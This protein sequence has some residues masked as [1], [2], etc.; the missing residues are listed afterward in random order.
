MTGPTTKRLDTTRYFRCLTGLMGAMLLTQP[1]PVAAAAGQADAEARR[2]ARRSPIVEAVET[3][4]DAVVNIAATQV[5]EVRDIFSEFFDEW[6]RSPAPRRQ[7]QYTSLGSGFPIHPDGYVVTNAHVVLRATSL[8]AVFADQQEYEAR[9]IAIDE[10]HDLA[11]LKI[12]GDRPLPAIRL[13]RSDDLMIG[14]TVIAIGNP[15]GYH[16]TVT[17]GIISATERTLN[18]SERRSY[19]DLIQTDASI[20]P[21]NSG[22]PLLNILG[23]LIGINT[24]IR[25]DAQNIGFAIPVDSLRKLLPDMLSVEQHRRLLVGLRLDWRSVPYV[26][27]IRGPATQTGIEPGDVLL[28]VNGV[29]INQDLDFYVYLLGMAPDEALR[30]RLQRGPRTV[31][32]TIWPQAIPIPDGAKLLRDKFGLTARLLS[33]EQARQISPRLTGGLAIESVESDSP[34]ERAGL[35]RGHLIVMI[36]RYFPTDP[37][38]LGQLLE[39]INRG[40][41]IP[42]R[43]MEIR[44]NGTIVMLEGELTAR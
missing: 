12:D 38:K 2:T 21:G 16:H 4:R 26:T 25:G 39:N 36:G 13:G 34:A 9:P 37:E 19:R 18:I 17:T 35:K 31:T 22:G 27:T 23:E 6:L 8:K 43:V 41:Q 30:V 28:S 40:D 33:P 44:R 29:E 7:R 20:N 3:S 42:V 1:G 14:E 32:A 10:E 15:L 5:V 11:V 24:A